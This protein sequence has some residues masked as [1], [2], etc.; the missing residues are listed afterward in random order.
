MAKKKNADKVKEEVKLELTP[1]IDVTFLILIFFMCTLKF[2]TLESKIDSYL[3]LDKGLSNAP[4]VI[5]ADD[6]EIELRVARDQHGKKLEEREVG[7]RRGG[8]NTFF[9]ISKGVWVDPKDHKNVKILW[10]PPDTM[11]QVREYMKN[12]RQAD[13][14]AKAKIKPW[15]AT[16]HLYV[17]T[18]LD[19]MRQVGFIDVS[20]TGIPNNLT[21]QLLSG[22]I[23]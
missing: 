7:I 3:P 2:K 4:A 19:E 15:S 6:L 12:I 22:E 17:V 20:Y 10:D 1:M 18:I 5:P 16:P 21:Q 8:T 13:P 11:E 23:K 14:E 9:G